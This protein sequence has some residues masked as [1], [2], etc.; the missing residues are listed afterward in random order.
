MRLS[1]DGQLVLDKPG[2]MTSRAALDRAR[3]W[4]PRRRHL[5]DMGIGK[6]SWDNCYPGCQLHI[7]AGSAGKPSPQA[8]G[9]PGGC[10]AAPAGKQRCG[11]PP[12]G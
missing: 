3:R 9:G 1:V 8:P 6:G 12:L 4:F 2:G 10:R 5:S 7:Q 11:R